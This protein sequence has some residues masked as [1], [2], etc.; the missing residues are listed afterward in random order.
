MFEKQLITNVFVPFFHCL[1]LNNYN[2]KDFE[3]TKKNSAVVCDNIK[4]ALVVSNKLYQILGLGVDGL[5]PG[6]CCNFDEVNCFSIN[7]KL[8]Y[9]FEFATFCKSL[10]DLL[11]L[12]RNKN[13]SGW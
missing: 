2:A 8:M 4:F 11:R 3:V 12:G 10:F 7:V 6:F 1:T 13:M 9:W 5:L